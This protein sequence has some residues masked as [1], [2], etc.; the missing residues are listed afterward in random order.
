MH[1]FRSFAAVGVAA[2]TSVLVSGC[3]SPAAQSAVD[4]GSTGH[5]SPPAASSRAQT[6]IVHREQSGN[7]SGGPGPVAVRGVTEAA[8]TFTPS[9]HALLLTDPNLAVVVRGVV[10]GVEYGHDEVGTTYTLVTLQI[11]ETI[12]GDVRGSISYME[13]GGF[14]KASDLSAI[15]GPKDG[16]PSASPDDGWVDVQFLGATHSEIGDE[17]VVFLRSN[18]QFGY[19]VL[20]G[21]YGRYVW[22]P[23]RA[24]WETLPADTIK[25]PTMTDEQVLG[26]R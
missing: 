17:Q 6:E 7:G 11:D 5:T 13:L 23:A 19:E 16:V 25:D 10:T 18:S 24:L 4:V 1:T 12:R 20:Q 14:I 26:L 2:V 3:G 21:P 8:L 9:D 22:N 15:N